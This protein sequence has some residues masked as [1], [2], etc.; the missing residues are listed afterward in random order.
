MITIIHYKPCATCATLLTVSFRDFVASCWCREEFDQAYNQVREGKLNYLLVV[1]LQVPKQEILNEWPEM[2]MY[3]TT[4]T[5]IDA[6]LHA[7]ELDEI[8]KGLR[9]AMPKKSLKELKVLNQTKI[10][11]ASWLTS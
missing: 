8:K 3:H 11:E 4:H 7:T 6:R 10:M 5:Y 1:L 2:D 9:F